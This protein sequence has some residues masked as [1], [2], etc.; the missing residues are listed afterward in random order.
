MSSLRGCHRTS[1]DSAYLLRQAVPRAAAVHR[2]GSLSS[3]AQS[4]RCWPCCSC[5]TWCG[6]ALACSGWWM[7][8][9]RSPA[10]RVPCARGSDRF[11]IVRE[12]PAQSGIVD[13][14]FVDTAL[15]PGQTYRSRRS[16]ECRN[17][18][19]YRRGE[20]S[21]R[22]PAQ[23]RDCV[24]SLLIGLGWKRLCCE[25]WQRRRG[26]HT[27]KRFDQLRFRNQIETCGEEG[28]PPRRSLV[29]EAN[30]RCDANE[31]RVSNLNIC[32]SCPDYHCVNYLV[33]EESLS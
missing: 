19:R 6:R 30:C 14:S 2:A 23:L 12:I 26:L 25:K 9:Y 32:Q 20:W 24:S 7:A 16:R 33:E 29:G 17:G 31:I 13:Y 1:C 11:E 28:Q 3:V 8:Q 10:S 18:Q 22:V 5:G 4:S 15:W 21:G 27:G